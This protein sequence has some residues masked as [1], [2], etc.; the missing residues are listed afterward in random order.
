MKEGL[1]RIIDRVK[2]LSRP[3]VIVIA[4]PTC[5]G[6]TFLAKRLISVLANEGL[7]ALRVPLD[8][9]FKDLADPTLPRD[10][11]GRCIFDLPQAY[12]EKEF[13]EAVTDLQAEKRIF[14]PIYDRA[15]NT[16]KAG[17]GIICRSLPVIIAE[18]LFAIRILAGLDR[19]VVRV[20]VDT[21]LDLCLKRRIKRDTRRYGVSPEAVESFFRNKIL[22]YHY[23]MEEQRNKADIILKG[24]DR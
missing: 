2:T 22:P 12:H 11:H 1:R 18:G 10:S 24:G 21:D 7:P 3:T 16:R 19:S 15:T 23:L 6:K 13:A 8:A 9:Y 4:G 17:P 20:Y 5:S 14:L